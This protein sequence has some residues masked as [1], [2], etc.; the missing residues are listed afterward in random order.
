MNKEEYF[1]FAEKFYWRLLE[2]SKEKN[3]D[4]TGGN[5][6]PFANFIAVEQYHVKT[7]HG[8][9]TRMSDKMMRIASYIHTG[10][11][12]VK[13]ESVMDTLGDLANYCILLAGYIKSKNAEN[14]IEEYRN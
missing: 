12:Q 3:A 11:L 6:N 5:E 9:L 4:Y 10:E 7:E 8:F 13:D 1:E 2:I 14:G